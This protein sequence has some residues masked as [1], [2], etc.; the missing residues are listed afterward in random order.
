MT[1]APTPSDALASLL[2]WLGAL[3]A[4]ESRSF[5]EVEALLESAEER[6][7]DERQGEADLHD[8]PDWPGL[9]IEILAIP[10]VVAALQLTSPPVDIDEMVALLR[11][12]HILDEWH[13]PLTPFLALP[14]DFLTEEHDAAADRLTSQHRFNNHDD[15]GILIPAR[16]SALPLQMDPD[17][18]IALMTTHHG[19][20]PLQVGKG[21][22]LL[23]AGLLSY[24]A[25]I[26]SSVLGDDVDDP[27]TGP[28]RKL[29]VKYRQ[30]PALPLSGRDQGR[31]LRISV[32]PVLQDPIDADLHF[33]SPD[34]TGYGVTPTSKPGRLQE[35]L[36]RARVDGTELLLMPEMAVADCDLPTLADSIEQTG[37]AYVQ[38]NR[39]ASPLRYVLAGLAG[40]SSGPGQHHRN[41]LV[42]LDGTSGAEVAYQSKLFRWNLE[43]YK[44]KR[45]GLPQPVRGYLPLC[46]EDI[47]AGDELWVLDL[48]GIGRLATLICA[49]VSADQPGDWLFTNANL[50]WFNAP[51][52]DQS[53]RWGVNGSKALDQWIAGRAHRAA[54]ATGARVI[55]TNSMLLSQKVNEANVSAGVTNF[56]LFAKVEV[57][58]LVDGSEGAPAY[59]SLEVPITVTHT[60]VSTVDWGSD[61]KAFPV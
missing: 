19:G 45:Y 39:E 55:V 60:V 9:G 49:D 23:F 25:F 41:R 46:M 56:P 61:F 28:K 18:R 43:D 50:D 6:L 51:I 30:L 40:P 32:A 29:R 34:G 53:T 44:Q 13:R 8:F 11:G 38:I 3:D 5:A 7:E 33:S 12:I 4:D 20:H 42:I 22:T 36:E 17:V 31:P 47:E 14:D 2:K 57:G 59:Q 1:S 10:M 24:V 52:M 35:V 21:K 26:P 27:A 37:R 48:D 15:D 54:C 16:S 58:L